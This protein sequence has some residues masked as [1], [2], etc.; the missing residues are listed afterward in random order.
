[1]RVKAIKLMNF[2][3]GISFLV[4]SASLLVI[5]FIK[6]DRELPLIAYAVAFAFWTG[7]VVG[8][9][10][11]IFLA[12]K[13]KRMSLKS[14]DKKHRLLYIIAFIALV[15][16]V[17]F[18]V[19]NSSNFAVVTSLSLFLLSMQEALVIKRRGYLNWKI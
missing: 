6:F 4:S 19:F 1:M 2:V 12:I 18:S 11:Q 13:C 16:V 15:L 5:P 7:L 10:I 3:S 17:V 8:I 9:I 14:N